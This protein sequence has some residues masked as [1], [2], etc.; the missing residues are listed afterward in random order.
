MG[1]TKMLATGIENSHD[2]PAFRAGGIGYIGS[3]DPGV[4]ITKAVRA[5]TGNA[6]LSHCRLFFQTTIISIPL[7]TN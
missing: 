7:L 3:K 5:L 1:M 4:T 6:N 2:L